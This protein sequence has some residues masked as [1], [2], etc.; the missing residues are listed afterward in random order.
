L[1]R[2]DLPTFD[3][4]IRTI[5]LAINPMNVANIEKVVFDRAEIRVNVCV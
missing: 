3:L 4:P 1:K 2:V 5:S